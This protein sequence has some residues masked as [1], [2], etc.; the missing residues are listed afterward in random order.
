MSED[1]HPKSQLVVFHDTTCDKMFL[2]M[3]TYKAEETVVFEGKE[4]P[5]CKVDT[6]SA[7][8]PIYTGGKRKASQEGAI[9]K[10]RQKYARRGVKKPE[11][12]KEDSK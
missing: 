9:A 3:S 10:F 8:H 6:S 4:Y 2:M 1:K 11:E 12:S 5:V 7:S